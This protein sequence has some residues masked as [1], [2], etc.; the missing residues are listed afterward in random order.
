MSRLAGENGLKR[1][2]PMALSPCDEASVRGETPSGE[3]MWSTRS[4]GL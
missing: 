4:S 3:K 2:S 1:I